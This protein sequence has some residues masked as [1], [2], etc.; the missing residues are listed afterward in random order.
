M[1]CLSIKIPLELPSQLKYMYCRVK[2]STLIT[3]IE[4]LHHQQSNT[5]HPKVELELEK[6]LKL[7]LENSEIYETIAM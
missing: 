1:L 7:Y 2:K 6:Y 4:F 3:S 5:V